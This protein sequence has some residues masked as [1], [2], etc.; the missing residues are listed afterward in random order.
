MPSQV[1]NS[2][3][4][5]PK[6]NVEKASTTPAA[7]KAPAPM[8]AFLADLPSSALASSISLR[9]SVETSAIALWTSVP[10]E[11][12]SAPA[13]EFR[14][15]GDTLWATRAPPSIGTAGHPNRAARR[16][17]AR[18]RLP[19]APLAGARPEPA[20][21]GGR[22]GPFSVLGG[23]RGQLLLD[24]VHHR[25]VGQ[26]RHVAELAVLGDV[27]QEAAHDLARAGLGELLHDHDLARLEIGR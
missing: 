22:G 19:P 15:A 9:T 8:P 20:K 18:L 25:R 2:A 16:R 23:C 27:A 14:E 4:A 3:K 21:G 5:I 26:R 6:K 11:G 7:P 10:T 1:R 12:S 24:H 13:V 17:S